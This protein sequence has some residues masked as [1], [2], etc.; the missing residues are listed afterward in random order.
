M[1]SKQ[2][3]G[4][5]RLFYS[6]VLDPRDQTNLGPTGWKTLRGTQK[7]AQAEFGLRY[8]PILGKE[9]NDISWAWMELV[10]EYFC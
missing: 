7:P 1:L 2:R 8:T 3:P 10:P 5:R 9:D 4:E 6:A